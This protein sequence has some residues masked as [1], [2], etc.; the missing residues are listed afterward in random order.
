MV[1]LASCPIGKTCKFSTFSIPRQSRR[2]RTLSEPCKHWRT[3]QNK[4]YIKFVAKTRLT[5]MWGRLFGDFFP[6]IHLDRHPNLLVTRQLLL[7]K[8]KPGTLC[9]VTPFNIQA[10]LNNAECSWPNYPFWGST[11]G[12]YYPTTHHRNRTPMYEQIIMPF[13]ENWISKEAP[14]TGFPAIIGGQFL[15][16]IPGLLWKGGDDYLLDLFQRASVSSLHCDTGGDQS[17]RQH[18][19]Q[20]LPP[21]NRKRHLKIRQYL[22]SLH[23]RKLSLG[24]P[25]QSSSVSLPVRFHQCPSPVNGFLGSNMNWTACEKCKRLSCWVCLKQGWITRRLLHQLSTMSSSSSSSFC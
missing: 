12:G 4:I 9:I 14:V 18:R 13:S 10:P 15:L 24:F 2:N 17:G 23:R 6:D 20:L 22:Y 25:H 1:L 19:D 16:Y 11:I 8:T 3:A 7:H 21:K 5:P